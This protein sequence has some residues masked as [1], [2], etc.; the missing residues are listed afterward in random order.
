MQSSGEKY[1]RYKISLKRE[2]KPTYTSCNQNEFTQLV[3]ANKK[4]R[5][6]KTEQKS[7]FNKICRFRSGESNSVAD[8]FTTVNVNM[9][10]AFALFLRLVIVVTILT[11]NP[12]S[13]VADVDEDYLSSDD[14]DDVNLST[15]TPT[16]CVA[17]VDVTSWQKI[18]TLDRRSGVL[19][20]RLNN[21]NNN[22]ITCLIGKI[23]MAHTFS[24]KNYYLKAFPLLKSD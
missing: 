6:N 5:K 10:R 23:M 8:G 24:G 11:S 19:D 22:V 21:V 13:A 16:N 20:V 2:A 4:F 12:A 14:V 1:F 7:D 15:A 17:L 9:I 18:L 3:S